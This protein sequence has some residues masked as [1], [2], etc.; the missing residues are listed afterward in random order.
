LLYRTGVLTVG[1]LYHRNAEAFM[2]LRA[3]WR[4]KPGAVPDAAVQ[5]TG[6][7]LL[8]VCPRAD[9]QQGTDRPQDALLNRLLAGEVPPWLRRI[10][11][12]PS[13]YV[14]YERLQ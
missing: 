2:R 8:L 11:A 3:A 7:S 13:G 12:E 6:A 10:G 1:S 9:Q 4:S 5:A 14:L